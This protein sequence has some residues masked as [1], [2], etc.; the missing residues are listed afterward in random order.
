[1][2]I[3]NWIF[4]DRMIHKEKIDEHSKIEW[5]I[6]RRHKESK[7]RERENEVTL[8]N[9]MWNYA[10]YKVHLSVCEKLQGW[11]GGWGSGGQGNIPGTPYK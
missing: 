7:Q 3:N 1:L 2:I 5:H 4:S 6:K 10:A 9:V 8:N 11:K